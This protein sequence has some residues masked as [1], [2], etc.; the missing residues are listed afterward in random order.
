MRSGALSFLAGILFAQQLTGL[1]EIWYTA[2]AVAGLAAIAVPRLRIAAFL[3]LGF[4]WAVWRADLVL[5]DQLPG[6]LE[7]ETVILEGR[8]VGLPLDLGDAERFDVEVAGLT[9]LRRAWPPPGVRLTWY[10]NARYRYAQYRNERRPVPGE[11]WR[12][13]ARLKRPHG[14]MN[15]GGL[16]YEGF[17]FRQGVRATGYVVSGTAN[18]RLR[19]AQGQVIERLRMAISDALRHRLGDRPE[20]GIVT[21]LAVGDQQAIDPVQ[22]NVFNR[23][24]TSHLVAISGLHVGFLGLIGYLLGRWLWSL[25]ARTV[26]YLAAPR[27]GAVTGLLMAWGYAALAGFAVPAVRSLVMI[28]VVMIGLWSHRSWLLIDLLA[29]ALWVVLL[30][31]PLAVLAP[32]MWLSFGAVAILVYA[33]AGRVS[34]RGLWWRFGRVHWVVGL[35]LMPLLFFLFGQNPVLGPLA[36]ALAVPWVTFVVVPLVLLGTALLWVSEPLATLLLHG[37]V[38]ALAWIWIYLEA[39]SDL[40]FATWHLPRPTPGV[41]AS[42]AIGTLLLLAPRGVPGRFTGLIWLLPLF[43]QRPAH[44]P[45]G[46]LWFTVLDVGQGLSAVAE[47]HRHVLVY[48]T[49]PK[50]SERL[51]AGRAALVPFLRERGIAHIDALV[52]SHGDNDH[53][54]GLRSLLAEVSVGRILTSVP[55]EIPLE[56][57]NMGRTVP[58]E[59]GQHWRWEGVA[60]TV[61]HPTADDPGSDN[62]RSCV[63]RVSTGARAVLIPGDIE[64]G[65]EARLVRRLGPTLHAEVLVAP[66]HGSKT[67]S[68]PGFVAAVS[69]RYVV[70]PAGYRNRWDFP[71]PE[72]RERYANRGAE[73]LSTAE[74]G[75]VRFRIGDGVGSPVRYRDETARYWNAR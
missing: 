23:T 4:L 48:D 18:T 44:P 24:G 19:P 15:P 42:A 12:L 33:M 1:P 43:L 2:L 66:H 17:L 38:E 14:M 69:P 55:Q 52:V 31:D 65:A 72:V 70:F 62:E 63:L 49:G 6:A 73:M 61:L 60:F 46:E 5:S 40:D 75:A 3:A 35:G 47:T 29:A 68:T 26:L 27:R 67:S 13:L 53:L 10:R 16:D 28:A 51:D 74:A 36:N 45:P 50:F 11:D 39:V 58:C 22:W 64:H 54:G 34:V 41:A 9:G 8:I 30:L 37:A 57:R 21:A 7:G 20:T 71:A 56:T 59:A 32:G 25:P